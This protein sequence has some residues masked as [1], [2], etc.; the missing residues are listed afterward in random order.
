[1][2]PSSC[3]LITVETESTNACD[4]TRGGKGRDHRIHYGYARGRARPAEL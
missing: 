2:T 3:A 4:Y 1:M